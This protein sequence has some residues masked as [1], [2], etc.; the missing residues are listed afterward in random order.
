MRIEEYVKLIEDDMNKHREFSCE[1][2]VDRSFLT[3]IS[4]FTIIKNFKGLRTVENILNSYKVTE[5]EEE[6]RDIDLMK[7][8]KRIR[9]KVNEHASNTFV[10]KK[11]IEQKN[12]ENADKDDLKEEL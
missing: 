3:L 1:A 12:K 10:R 4:Y 9:E 5:C 6:G 2:C 8:P 7:V 11:V